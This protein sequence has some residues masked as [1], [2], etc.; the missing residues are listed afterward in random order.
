[1]KL[2]GREGRGAR[3]KEANL[4]VRDSTHEANLRVYKCEIVKSLTGFASRL[5]VSKHKC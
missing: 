1:M 2:K 5:S 4:G 3:T